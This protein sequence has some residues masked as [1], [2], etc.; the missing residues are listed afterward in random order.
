M[1][2]HTLI[3]RNPRREQREV[4][5][6]RRLPKRKKIQRAEIRYQTELNSEPRH[7]TE[8]DELPGYTWMHEKVYLWQCS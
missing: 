4:Q 6:E 1:Q 7:S 3:T 8:S 5:E 2:A